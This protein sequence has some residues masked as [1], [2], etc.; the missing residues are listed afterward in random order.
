MSMLNGVWCIIC[1]VGCIFHAVY[2]ISS[3]R[4][5]YQLSLWII[6]HYSKECHLRCLSLLPRGK[7]QVVNDFPRI[8]MGMRCFV[9][10]FNQMLENLEIQ[11]VFGCSVDMTTDNLNFQ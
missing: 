1:L 8:T 9:G 10:V 7:W 3:S 11:T 6:G 2:R 5:R 4:L